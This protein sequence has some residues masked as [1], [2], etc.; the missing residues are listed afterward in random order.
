MYNPV[1]LF[2]VIISEFVEAYGAILISM[3]AQ[4][5]LH[6]SPTNYKN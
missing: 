3:L 5:K 1:T 4:F 2:K 6:F